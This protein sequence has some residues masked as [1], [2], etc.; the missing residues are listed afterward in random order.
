[1]S[2]LEFRYPNSSD[3]NRTILQSVMNTQC[4]L[5]MERLECVI[6]LRAADTSGESSYCFGADRNQVKKSGIGFFAATK[7]DKDLCQPEND[8]CPQLFCHRYMICTLKTNILVAFFGIIIFLF[9][10]VGFVG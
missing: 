10:C 7:F 3:L 9:V 4:S 1:M 6:S 5:Y 8:L 2:E